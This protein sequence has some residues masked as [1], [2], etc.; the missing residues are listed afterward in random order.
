M[1]FG[2]LDP[3]PSFFLY[4]SGSVILFVRILILPSTSKKIKNNLDLYSF[5]TS[6]LLFIFEE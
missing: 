2:L 6:L 3:D 4:E 1:L 5:V